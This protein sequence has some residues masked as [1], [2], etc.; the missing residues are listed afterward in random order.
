MW[1]PHNYFYF[2]R[3]YLLGNISYWTKCIELIHTICYGQNMYL[4]FSYIVVY[5]R[6][7]IQ[8]Y[9]KIQMF[10]FYLNIIS[11]KMG[12]TKSSRNSYI[13]CIFNRRNELKVELVFNNVF[14]IIYGM[15]AAEAVQNI[16]IVSS[17]GNFTQWLKKLK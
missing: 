17:W 13:Y 4:R 12:T 5:H 14:L 6:N 3:Q 2:S 8:Q 16:I 10:Y 15:V 1:S 7:K 11:I 9:N